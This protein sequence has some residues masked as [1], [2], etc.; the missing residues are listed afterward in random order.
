M[1]LLRNVISFTYFQYHQEYLSFIL[2]S[3]DFIK[4]SLN[5]YFPFGIMEKWTM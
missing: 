3:T 4:N 5:Y 2:K 1:S